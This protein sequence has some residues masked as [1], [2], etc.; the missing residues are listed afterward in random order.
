MEIPVYQVDAFTSEPFRGNPAAVCIVGEGFDG[1]LMQLVA[2]EMN[3]SETAFVVRREGGFGLRWFTPVAEVDL[4]GHATLAAAH[5]LW[6]EGVAA[7]GASISFHTRSGRLGA[8]RS[9]G[10]IEL[11]LPADPVRAA[12]AP[13]GLLEALG[14][15]EPLFV[16]RGRFDYLVEV[17]S[18]GELR[19]LTPEMGALRGVETR[20]V[21]VT[22]RAAAA[23]WDFLSRF[24]APA[25]GIDE[26]PVTGSAHCALGP[27]WA[28]RLGRDELR[29]FQASRRG[30]EL[31]VRSMGRR[32]AVGGRAVTVLEGRLTVP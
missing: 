29:A 31:T 26:D 27:Y 19:S 11:D 23:P 28:R 9:D 3:L 22:C 6:R 5:V 8:A 14:V 24:F 1:S 10:I 25:A 16:G 18:E 17:D 4:C 13:E 2:A 32:V 15:V 12:E 21:I 20:G 7:D 30:G